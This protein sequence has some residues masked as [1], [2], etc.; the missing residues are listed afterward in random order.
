VR[1]FFFKIFLW[2]WFAM[3]L[4]VASAVAATVTL[5]PTGAMD[6]WRKLATSPLRVAAVGAVTA[7]EQGG[8]RDADV[9]LRRLAADTG[10]K[11]Y[12]FDAEGHEI[13]TLGASPIARRAAHTAGIARTWQMRAGT[14]TTALAQRLTGTHR[15][16]YIL[17][18]V[19][20]VYLPFH[21]R[22]VVIRFLVVTM[23]GGLICAW[24]ARNIAAPI[25][26]LR[27]TARRLATGE[28]AARV[29]RSVT[30][31][32]DELA[33]LGR[34]FDVMAE[35]LESLITA[36]RR[37][38]ADI[39]HELRSP[40]ARLTVASALARRDAGDAPVPALDRIEREAGRLNELIGELTT[41]SRLESGVSESPTA[42]VDLRDLLAAIVSDADYE[43]REQNKRVALSIP[44]DSV[45]AAAPLIVHGDAELL[46]RGLEN[47]IRNAIRYTAPDTAVE[48]SLAREGGW[49]VTAVHD[50]GPGVPETA[51]T[52][53]FRPFYR[54]QDDRGRDTGGAGLGLAIAD[55]AIRSH[56]GAIAA[57]NA[58]DGGLA[59]TIRI[60]VA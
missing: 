48:V 25:A 2:F 39:S 28:L 29:P 13:S 16:R 49:A 50:H 32:H 10:V 57:K 55:R 6:R 58:P 36:Q 3:V 24:L 42:P 11:A 18:A 56:G 53:I 52:E 44:P 54:L 21:D 1:S 9:Y 17:V 37:L 38:L 60:P 59:V 14:V 51:L 40:L 8:A 20:R 23:T 7:Y 22:S 30:R 5:Q 12:L 27:R 46:R 35:H 41:L 4:V 19:E 15:R 47:V 34:D 31:R 33:Q 43:A 45:T 26:E